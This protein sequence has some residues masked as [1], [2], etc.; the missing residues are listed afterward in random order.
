MKKVLLP[1]LMLVMVSFSI[2]DVKLTNAERKKAI[3][4]MKNTS[5]HLV[6]TIKGLS[7]AQLH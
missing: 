3:T 6:T 1:L 5:K 4:E 2:S 7:E